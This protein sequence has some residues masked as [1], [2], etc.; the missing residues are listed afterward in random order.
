MTKCSIDEII[1]MVGN[2]L[3][4]VVVVMVRTGDEHFESIRWKDMSPLFASRT[5]ATLHRVEMRCKAWG[6]GYVR[7]G[8]EVM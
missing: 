4:G 8:E 7:F 2:S 5:Q 3:Q 1:M 6:R